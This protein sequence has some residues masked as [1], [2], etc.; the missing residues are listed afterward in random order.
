MPTRYC[1]V[2]QWLIHLR[3][4]DYRSVPHIR[5]PFCNLNA[6]RKH[7]GGLYAGSDILSR[8]YAPFSGATTRCWHNIILQTDR[9]CRDLPS[10]LVQ[11]LDERDRLTEVGHSVDS[12][13]FQAFRGFVLSMCCCWL[14]PLADTLAIDGKFLSCSVDAGSVLALPRGPWTWQCGSFDED[15]F[16]RMAIDGGPIREIKIPVQELWLKT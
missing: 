7:R 16:G 13:V 8:E 6:S 1:A 3:P 12:G 10:Q 14:T 4:Y 5:P 11:K 15:H 9:S 2:V